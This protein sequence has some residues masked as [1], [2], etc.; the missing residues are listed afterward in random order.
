M[1]ARMNSHMS[2]HIDIE[3]VGGAV[4]VVFNGTVVAHSR[5]ALVLREGSLAAVHYIPRADVRMEHLGHT[6]HHSHCPHKGDAS[7]W[8]LTVG[9]ES[10]E[11]AVWS[12]EDPLDEVAAIK[13]HMAFYADRVDAIEETE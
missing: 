4:K 9:G 13:D 8:T 11:N 5:R 6:D 12:Y 1:S 10:A 2:S 3:P 7:Y